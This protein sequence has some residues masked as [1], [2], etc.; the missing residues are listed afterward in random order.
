MIDMGGKTQCWIFGKERLKTGGKYEHFYAF[1]QSCDE[2]K[3]LWWNIVCETYIKFNYYR[4]NQKYFH[5]KMCREKSWHGKNTYPP[6]H[7]LRAL[8]SINDKVF[9]IPPEKISVIFDDFFK[10]LRKNHLKKDWGK[11]KTTIT[12]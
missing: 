5:W 6:H 3:K 8:S 12:E 9:F 2:P 11:M 10:I 4:L 7:C 1:R